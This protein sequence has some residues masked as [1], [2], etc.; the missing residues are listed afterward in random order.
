MWPRVG[1][2]VPGPME[3]ST[4]RCRPVDGRELVGDLARDPRAGL[5][6][7]VNALRD[8]VLGERRE[9]RA[10]GV[11]LDAVH[12]DREVRLVHVRT[13]S[14]RVTL[15]TSL[16]PSSCWKSSIV[17]SCAW[18][19]VPMAPSATTTRVAKGLAQ[20]GA[21]GSPVRATAPQVAG[22]LARPL[23]S[24]GAT[25]RAASAPALSRGLRVPPGLQGTSW[26]ARSP[27]GPRLRDPGPRPV[28]AR[29]PA[30]KASPPPVGS[31]ALYGGPPGP[32]RAPQPGAAMRTPSAPGW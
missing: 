30:R 15:R 20:G 4:Q 31:A 6:Q 25:I 21:H 26:P 24:V 18:S 19:I 29:N 27:A 23:L 16:Q 17:G 14:G 1:S 8:V 10:E 28:P 3:P 5:R 7:L 22:E 32:R 12:A 11:R 9:V 2:L 13:M